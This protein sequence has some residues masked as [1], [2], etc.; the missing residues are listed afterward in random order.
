M[1]DLEAPSILLALLDLLTPRDLAL[2]SILLDPL[3]QETPRDLAAHSI[4]LDPLDL[5]ILRDLAHHSTHLVLLVLPT[6]RDLAAPSILPD[7]LDLVTLRDQDLHSI[8]PDLLDLLTHQD[9]LDLTLPRDQP[10]LTRDTL[11]EAH[12]NLPQ[13]D[14]DPVTV[15]T[16][17]TDSTV[18]SAVASVAVASVATMTT[19]STA[20]VASPT[21][22]PA[23]STVSLT[24]P[25]RAVMDMESPRAPSSANPM[26]APP[27]ME[28]VM[29]MTS[30]TSRLVMTNIA[31]TLAPMISSMDSV[32][33]EAADMVLSMA[34]GEQTRLL[35]DCLVLLCNKR[36]FITLTKCFK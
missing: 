12:T 8:L 10:P 35:C 24:A 4:L 30:T 11:Q 17:T 36:Q 15:L 3:A 13:S 28:E 21:S 33:S 9:P 31:N 14:T 22:T 18:L 25:A 34:S 29:I 19:V 26:V 23:D 1:G 5:L 16:S 6:L 27:A 2:H 32:V 20:S 7:P